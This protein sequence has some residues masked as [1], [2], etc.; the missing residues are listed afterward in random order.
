MVNILMRYEDGTISEFS[1]KNEEFKKRFLG[2]HHGSRE[3]WFKVLKEF[4]KLGLR[5]IT[6]TY[7]G[8]EMDYIVND[9]GT[10]KSE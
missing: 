3:P 2:G 9:N 4:Y 6:I 10:Y 5:K 7:N 1:M 8:Y